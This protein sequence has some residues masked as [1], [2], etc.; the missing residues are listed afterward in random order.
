MEDVLGTFF[1]IFYYE[2][3]FFLND[4]VLVHLIWVQIR[5]LNIIWW[6]E[7]QYMQIQVTWERNI[8]WAISS[9]LITKNCILATIS[10]QDLGQ[11]CPKISTESF[12]Q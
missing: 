1:F 9:P 5:N 2:M 4:C 10:N 7:R 6:Y 12:V 8:S 3:T 11:N